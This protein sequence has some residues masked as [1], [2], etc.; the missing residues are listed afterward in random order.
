MRI[1]I[2]SQT[3]VKRPLSK[4]PKI[5]FQ[6]Q[7][8]LNVGQKYC[9]LQYC[10]TS[11][12][13]Q[14]S[15]RPLL[16][17]SLSGRFKTGFTVHVAVCVKWRWRWP[18]NLCMLGKF[19]SFCRLLIFFKTRDFFKNN[20]SKHH[21]SCQTV[22]IQIRPDVLSSLIWVQTVCK[23]CQKTTLVDTDL[24]LN[25]PIATKV[26]CFSRLLKCIS[27]LYGKLCGPRSD[28]SYWCGLFW[29]HTVCFYT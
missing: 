5:G 20:I 28:C 13:Y 25:A 17:L 29:V 4:T 14:L 26:V 23:D 16:C 27:S 8:S 9:I 6:D 10:R 24:T 22:R 1:Y 7:L 12:S 18:L 3:C 11:L 19:V 15:L 21:R 2:N